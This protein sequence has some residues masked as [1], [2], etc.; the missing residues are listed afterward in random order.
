MAPPK[1]TSL[2]SLPALSLPTSMSKAFTKEDDLAL[3]DLPNPVALRPPGTRNLITPRGEQRLRA[4]LAQLETERTPLVTAP[5]TDTDAKHRLQI[6]DRKIQ[7]HQESLAAAEVVPSPPPKSRDT[8]QF[9]ARVTLRELDGSE[10]AYEIVGVDEA[11][12]AEGRI[13][14]L[15]PLA[16]ALMGANVGEPITFQAPSGPQKLQVLGITYSE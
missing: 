9:G 16:R 4:A 5:A 7:Q 8:V 14:W 2:S 11:D 1:E 13:S 15:S 3:P 10:S 6:L 12:F